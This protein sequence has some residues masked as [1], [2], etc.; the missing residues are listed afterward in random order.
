MKFVSLDDFLDKVEA[1]GILK[2]S[3]LLVGLR[4][5]AKTGDADMAEEAINKSLHNIE[6]ELTNRDICLRRIA[7]LKDKLNRLQAKL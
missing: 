5:F 4:T 3:P 7:N 6:Y 1:T 2:T